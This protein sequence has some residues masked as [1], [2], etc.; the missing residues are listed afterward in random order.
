MRILV[1]GSRFWTSEPP[2]YE[3]LLRWLGEP[4]VTL[5]SGACPPRM[6]L[7][8]WYKGADRICEEAARA[9]GWTVELHPAEWTLHGKRAGFLRNQEMVDLG[10][11]YCCAFILNNSAGATM[12]ERIARKAG[13]PTIVVREER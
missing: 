4:Q 2:I 11:D 9:Y 12:T 6:H 7:G 10:A 8:R 1:T 13:I 3:T 5:V